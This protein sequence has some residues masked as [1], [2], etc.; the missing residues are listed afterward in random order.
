MHTLSTDGLVEPPLLRGRSAESSTLWHWP[1]A[2]DLNTPGASCA[3]AL[4]P[5]PSPED[6]SSPRSVGAC[7]EQRSEAR[8]LTDGL[9]TAASKLAPRSETALRRPGS[10]GADSPFA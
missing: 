10:M 7:A 2:C 5:L 4:Q 9:D 6:G 3:G 8:K 1:A